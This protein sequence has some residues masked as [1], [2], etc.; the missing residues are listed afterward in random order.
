MYFPII[1]TREYINLFENN[2]SNNI[3]QQKQRIVVK[4][5]IFPSKEYII[6]KI[7]PILKYYSENGYFINIKNHEEKEITI[8]ELVDRYFD[9]TDDYFEIDRRNANQNPL[10]SDC[11]K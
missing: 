10:P 5:T 2:K 9:N 1:T 8:D 4:S 7:E 3:L 11:S 6:S